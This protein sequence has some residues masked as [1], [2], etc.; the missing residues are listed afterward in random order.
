MTGTSYRSCSAQARP[1]CAVTRRPALTAVDEE[2]RDL[3]QYQHLV[4]RFG[5]VRK[6]TG[7]TERASDSCG[8][9]QRRAARSARRARVGATSAAR[10]RACA[11]AP[12]GH[13]GGRRRPSEPIRTASP[14]PVGGGGTASAT[15]SRTSACRSAAETRAYSSASAGVANVT[16]RAAAPEP[17]AREHPD[18]SP[19]QALAPRQ[20]RPARTRRARGVVRRSV[21]GA[22]G[23]ATASGR[24][25]RGAARR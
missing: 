10:R 20:V 22:R 18:L 5:A 24:G 19:R 14:M 23:P 15:S 17:R 25:S 11:S 6:A 3:E 4:G 21:P 13:A 2:I 16:V 7:V 9:G 8:G 12:I 1:E